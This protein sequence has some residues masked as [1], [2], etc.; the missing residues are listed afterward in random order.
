MDDYT[1]MGLNRQWESQSRFDMAEDEP[2]LADAS[3]DELIRELELRQEANKRL[4]S[5]NHKR[6]GVIYYGEY[7][8]VNDTLEKLANELERELALL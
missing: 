1:F 8:A 6:I 4:S 5:N 3:T 2:T 7:D